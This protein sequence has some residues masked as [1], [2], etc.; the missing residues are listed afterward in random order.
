MS[1][2]EHLQEART[3]FFIQNPDLAASIEEVAPGVIAAAGMTVED[4]RQQKRMEVYARAEKA[5]GSDPFRFCAQILGAP[6]AQELEWRVE[7]HRAA[8]SAMGMEWDDYKKLNRF[9]E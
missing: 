7:Y 9:S 3:L 8:A 5:S 4:Y 2:K 6:A 1:F